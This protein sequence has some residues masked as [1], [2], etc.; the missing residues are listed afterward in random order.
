M[1]LELELDWAEE[2]DKWGYGIDLKE[3]LAKDIETYI[4]VKIYKNEQDN[5]MDKDL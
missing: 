2:M 3:A 4:R 1:A 5:K